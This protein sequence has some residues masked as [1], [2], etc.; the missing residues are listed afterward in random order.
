[1]SLGKL[2]DE[3]MHGA[4]DSKEGVHGRSEWCKEARS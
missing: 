3:Q 2:E 4:M 1:M